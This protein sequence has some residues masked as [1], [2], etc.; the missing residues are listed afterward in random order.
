VA[1]EAL[2]AGAADVI[3]KPVRL[4]TLLGKLTALV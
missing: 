2:V 4:E 1:V 3:S